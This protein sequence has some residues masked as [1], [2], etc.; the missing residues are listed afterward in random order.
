MKAWVYSAYGQSDVL[1]LK[2]VPKPS[3]KD[4]EV[5]VRIHAVSLNA[6]DWEFL[7]GSPFYARI[8]GLFK[9]GVKILGSDIA[10]YVEAVG[11]SV[12]RFKVGDAVFGDALSV[13]G[14][15]AEY[16]ALPE[17]LLVQK[18]EGIGLAEAST[19]PQA[20]VVALQGL[21]DKGKIEA[22]DNVLIN[23]A[24]G[25]A[26]TFAIQLAKM[27]G[28]VVTGV[29]SA[30]KQQVMRAVRADHVF[31]Y[32][33]DDF[34]AD[35]EQYDLILDFVASRS[36][37]DHKR[38]LK[39]KGRY[40]V[41]GGAVPR[42]LQTLLLSSFVKWL[43]GKEMGILAYQQNNDDLAYLL[44]LNK[45]GTVNPVIDQHFKFEDTPQALQYLGDGHAKGKIIITFDHDAG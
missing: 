29:D 41:V 10:G 33:A 39:P 16:A 2:E 30:E 32:R 4:D 24:G 14:G 13:F 11:S 6:S 35:G 19:F 1:R 45:A 5:L 21:R 15:L 9:P 20:G 7:I 31:D 40:V 34:T 12:T 8:G 25:G 3:F 18:P 26:G 28:A 43:S 38:S 44:G 22:G 23:G 37:L 36:P 17:K 42:L 27:Y